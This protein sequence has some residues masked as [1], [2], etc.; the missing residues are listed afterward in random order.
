MNRD[1]HPATI[2][3]SEHLWQMPNHPMKLVNRAIPDFIKMKQL[4]RNAKHVYP[5][6][7]TIKMARRMNPTA[8]IAQKV[9]TRPARRQYRNATNVLL[10]K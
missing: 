9:P 2:A 6:N 10:E 5:A 8:K 7:G 4:D 1:K 3:R